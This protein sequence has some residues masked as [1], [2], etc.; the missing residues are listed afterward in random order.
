MKERKLQM[1]TA[2][3]AIGAVAS[4]AVAAATGTAAIKERQH[5]MEDVGKAMGPLVGIAKKQ[6][7]FD[8]EVVKASAETIAESLRKAAELFP[9]G[10]DTGDVET[11][12]KAAIWSDPEDFQ[13]RF[14]TAI[15]AAVAMQSVTD[16]G[17]FMPALGAVGNGCKTCHDP[18]RRPKK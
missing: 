11:W 7:E 12:A 18:Y 10:S 1:L 3:V 16:E 15:A 2:I 17:A 6:A 4:I 13:K 8:A 14:E 5:A 9:E